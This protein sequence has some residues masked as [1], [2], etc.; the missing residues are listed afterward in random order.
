MLFGHLGLFQTTISGNGIAVILSPVPSEEL[1]MIDLNNET[2]SVDGNFV[3]MRT[4]SLSYTIGK[5]GK[6]WISTALSGEGFFH[7]FKGTGKVWLAPTQSVYKTLSEKAS[8]SGLMQ[9]KKLRETRVN[10]KID[11]NQNVDQ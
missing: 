1:L 5:S 6:G 11:A 7:T 2:L 4:A 10:N 3:L 9:N 8:I